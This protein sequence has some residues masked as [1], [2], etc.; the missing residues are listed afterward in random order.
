MASLESLPS[1]EIIQGYK[2][3]IDYFVTRGIPCARRWPRYSKSRMSASSLQAAAL[4]GQI[5]QAY[6]LLPANVKQELSLE[7]ADQ[8]RSGRD[9]WVSGVLGHLHERS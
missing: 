6:A 8:P 1:L 3:V 9:I 5:V 7:A 4:F 2:G